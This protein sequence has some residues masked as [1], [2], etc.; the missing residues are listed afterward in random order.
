MLPCGIP[1]CGA[2]VVVSV[3]LD[4]A[5]PVTVAPDPSVSAKTTESDPVVRTYA[6]LGGG[7]GGGALELALP[8]DIHGP[9][10]AEPGRA[11]LVDGA[12]PSS[13]PSRSANMSP[14]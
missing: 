7:V 4:A 3:D 10:A 13:P 11:I 6:A 1:D 5:G 9:V 14:T 12:E 2:G 8:A